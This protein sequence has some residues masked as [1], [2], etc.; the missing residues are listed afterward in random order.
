MR[1]L[2]RWYLRLKTQGVFVCLF[3]TYLFAQVE[4]PAAIQLMWTC[5]ISTHWYSHKG[6]PH[7]WELHALLFYLVA[8]RNKDVQLT[9]AISVNNSG[10]EV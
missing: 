1:F 10:G 3:V 9:G 7:H 5:Y 6:Q 2:D 4:V 8:K